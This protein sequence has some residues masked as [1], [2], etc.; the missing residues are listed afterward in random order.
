[1]T[2]KV[3]MPIF[4][5]VD[6]TIFMVTVLGLCSATALYFAKHKATKAQEPMIR[7]EVKY[8]FFSA[9]GKPVTLTEKEV[10]GIRQMHEDGMQPSV[11]GE[12][13]GLET[14]MVMRIINCV[15]SI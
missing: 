12:K 11:I 9:D 15:K 6:R 7:K 5:L 10:Y 8:V 13:F 1:M 2:P 3:T 4:N 14:V